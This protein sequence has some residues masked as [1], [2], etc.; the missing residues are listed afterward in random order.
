[1]NNQL[2]E[3]VVWI[4]F[5]NQ[6]SGTKLSLQNRVVNSKPVLTIQTGASNI[7]V[8]YDTYYNPPSDSGYVTTPAT[9]LLDLGKNEISN[10]GSLTINALGNVTTPN[11]EFTTSGTN[12]NITMAYD[13]TTG[14]LRYT[15]GR[16]VENNLN[17]WGVLY[18]TNYNR[19][20]GVSGAGAVH[21][22]YL[23]FTSS[24]TGAVINGAHGVTTIS[25]CAT[26]A[27]PT[28]CTL[29]KIS[30]TG[31]YLKADYTGV[32]VPAN[33]T[34]TLTFMLCNANGTIDGGQNS[35]GLTYTPQ[36]DF[37]QDIYT[38]PISTTIDLWYTSV[39]AVKSICFGFQSE[40]SL[41]MLDAKLTLI[42]C[43]ALVTG[44]ESTTDTSITMTAL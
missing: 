44:Y 22:N 33:A 39:T 27:F 21:T 16:W 10:V 3:G 19:P 5:N 13:P 36:S 23:L 17:N 9:K 37:E 4:E 35:W 28:P 43:H 29:F 40:P 32:T 42:T 41:G 11:I 34:E 25:Q 18:D 6:D 20:A 31:F 7:G 26:I 14:F 30:I 2:I 24:I 12:S 1:M 8:I 15:T 38:A